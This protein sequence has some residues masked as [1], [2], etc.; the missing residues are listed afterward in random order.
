MSNNNSKVRYGID[1]KPPIKELI[2]LSFQHVMAMFGST[3]LVPLLVGLSVNCALFTAG[4]GTLIFLLITKFKVPIFL[5]SSFAFIPALIAASQLGIEYMAGGVASSGL[6]YCIVSLIIS[7]TGTKW[8]NRAFS[9]VVIGSV[10]ICIGLCLAPTA[11]SMSTMVNGE[12]SLSALTIAIVTLFAT[13]FANNLLKGFASSIP[14]MIGL[15]FGYIFTLVMGTIFPSFAFIDFSSIGSAKWFAFPSFIAPKYN[16]GIVLAFLIISFS[17]MIEHI[18]DIYTASK[19]VGKELY[20][21]PGLNRTLL[22]D[23]LGTL[24]AGFFGG[25]NNTSYGENL[26]TLSISGVHSVY[27]IFWAAVTSVFLSLF[28]KFG[29]LI[30]TIPSPCLGGVSMLLF[31]SIA[32]SG[33]RNVVEVGV[34]YSDKRNLAIASV[35]MSAGIGGLGLQ[36]A[37][38]KST[39]FSIQGVALATVL[40]LILNFILPLDKNK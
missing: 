32:S 33:L 1:E 17:T 35:I 27:V 40:G 8:L 4:I 2:P 14:V 36:I 23:G 22:G 12:Y 19:I 18:G 37:L 30:S 6:L 15:V 7:K 38:G 16:I 13:I 3:V 34:N 9:P 5:G 20:K 39:M 11:V 21:E 25:P 24:F 28:P 10:I 29:A 31:G 26:A